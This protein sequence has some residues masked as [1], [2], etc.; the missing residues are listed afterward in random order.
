V[1]PKNSPRRFVVATQHILQEVV[2]KLLREG[3]LH[4]LPVYAVVMQSDLGREG[5][6]NSGSYRFADHI[7][8]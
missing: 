5:I 8:H 7:Y 3:N 1:H 6:I 2:R 4:W